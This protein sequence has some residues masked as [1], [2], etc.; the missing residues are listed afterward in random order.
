M[1][2]RDLLWQLA[3]GIVDEDHVVGHGVGPGIPR[4]QHRG[5]HLTG[6]IGDTEHRMEAEAALEGG[7]GARLVLGVDLDQGGVDVQEHRGAARRRRRPSPHLGSHRG[8]RLGDALPRLGRDLVE[9]AEH[10]RV[11]RH[12]AEQFLLEAEVLDVR[13]ALPA[14]G[15]HQGHLDED[16]APVVSPEPFTRPRDCSREGIAEPQP[17]GETAKSVQADMSHDAGSSGFH[18]GAT[19]AGTVHFGSALSFGNLLTSTPTVSPTG[20]AYPRTR[21]GQF[22]R[23]REWSGLAKGSSEGRRQVEPDH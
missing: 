5:Q 6:G 21:A 2:S 11:R 3:D 1:T 12:P 9:G 20:R 4:T 8:Q 13:A 19:G 23:P 16:L 14:A 7:S 17:V 22:R 10:R 15:Q 18:N